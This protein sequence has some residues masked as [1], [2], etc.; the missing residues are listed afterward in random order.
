MLY[1]KRILVSLALLLSLFFTG[2]ASVSN[3]RYPSPVLRGGDVVFPVIKVE[4]VTLS[5]FLQYIQ[6]EANRCLPPAG[7]IDLSARIKRE[8]V[9][10]LYPINDVIYI[11]REENGTVRSQ[12]LNFSMVDAGI[13]DILDKLVSVSGLSYIKEGERII[14]IHPGFA[15]KS[16]AVV[17]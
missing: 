17:D 13:K 2:C 9:S 8:G 15:P 5:A 1:S 6:R 4:Y 14:V 7:R 16:Y 10:M 11:M 12:L 3:R